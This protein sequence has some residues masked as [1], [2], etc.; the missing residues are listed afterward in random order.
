M[1]DDRR[2]QYP[3]Y[4]A[5][6]SSPAGPGLAVVAIMGGLA[7]GAAN[8]VPVPL[9]VVLMA[10][11]VG[12][13]VWGYQRNRGSATITA[14]EHLIVK[15]PLGSRTVPWPEIQQIVVESQAVWTA[16]ARE[17]RDVAVVYDRA[18]ERIVLPH[19]DNKSVA[20]LDDEV[21]ALR[22]LWEA[23]RGAT[24]QPAAGITTAIESAQAT[25]A[26]RGG[27]LIGSV[28]AGG[29]AFCTLVVVVVLATDGPIAA[30]I[31]LGVLPVV[32][33]VVTFVVM[34]N[35]QKNTVGAGDES[36]PDA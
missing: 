30:A 14:P 25:T 27:L 10:V 19:L 7:Y 15:R 36:A 20:S 17:P 3:A 23:R 31:L 9:V 32:A 2:A 34:L 18:G 26:R 28:L 22:T 16:Q 8:G 29:L 11:L 4:H 21:R 1:A 35:R 6:S 33:A 24:W 13:I 5:N 12:L